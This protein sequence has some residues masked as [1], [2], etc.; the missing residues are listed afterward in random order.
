MAPLPKSL[1]ELCPP[2]LFYLVLSAIGLVIAGFQNIGNSNLYT[3]GGICKPVSSTFLVF[4]VKIIYI[5]FWTWILNLIC[6]SGHKGIAWFLVLIPFI[7]LFV[8]VFLLKTP[9]I[10]GA[11]YSSGAKSQKTRDEEAISALIKSNIKIGQL[12]AGA[13]AYTAIQQQQ[14]AAYTAMER[15]KENLRR[16]QYNAVAAK[17]GKAPLPY[18]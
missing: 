4:I 10:E 7:L 3:L 9:I 8:I 18:I 16:I 11:T 5:L 6:G 14:A 1:K 15:Q 2:A 12:Q 13:P 17:F